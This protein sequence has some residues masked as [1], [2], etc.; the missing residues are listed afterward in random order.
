MLETSARE[1]A[2]AFGLGTASSLTGPVA[3]GR[4]GAI[5]RL[6]TSTGTYAVKV[7]DQ[8]ISA[9]D[10]ERDAALQDAFLA[11]GVP[12]PA[13]V[14]SVTGAVVATV[15]GRPVRVYEWVDVRPEDRR[16]DPAAVGRLVAAVHAVHLPP[17]GPVSPW[18]TEP[19]G[20]EDW[21][22]L[23]AR[24][25]RA[26][27]PYAERL[28]ALVPGLLEVEALLEPPADL[29]VCHRD[30]WADNLRATTSGELVA[31]DWENAGPASPTHELGLVVFEY[32]CG[33]PGRARTLVTAYADAGGPARLRTLGDFSMLVAVQGHLVREGCR[34]WLEA[35]TDEDRADNQAWVAEF[36]D[37]PFL[38]PQL[39]KM[40]A[41]VAVD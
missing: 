16:L 28:A 12:M 1:T 10:A 9:A 30:L 34:R 18:F 11:G 13:V 26:R 29:Q 41:A 32:A 39:E 33:D 36:L 4:L 20:A 7:G 15:S 22:S 23:V 24:L 8:P 5:W 38:L 40:A 25:R 27:A 31:L 19:V 14:R 21:A 2:D 37:E 6:E 35:A 17:D 3:R